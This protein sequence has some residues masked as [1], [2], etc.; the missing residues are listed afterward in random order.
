MIYRNVEKS[1]L[2]ITS[3]QQTL[4]SH[5]TSQDEMITQLVADAENT[6]TN[7]TKGNRELK[8]ASER[9]S[10]ARLVF[11]ATAGLCASLVVWDAIF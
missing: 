5:L 10:V 3:L 9:K 4:V 8:R 6:Q 1:L 7:V 11:Y 2:E